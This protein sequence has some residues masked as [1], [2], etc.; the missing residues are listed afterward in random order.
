MKPKKVL[1]MKKEKQKR[2]IKS[3]FSF[4]EGPSQS[5]AIVSL[6]ESRLGTAVE[7]SQQLL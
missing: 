3:N 1:I 5:A 6:T 4:L 2:I 7:Q